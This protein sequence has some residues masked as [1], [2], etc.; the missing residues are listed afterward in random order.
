MLVCLVWQPSYKML[1]LQYTLAAWLGWCC[2]WLMF[3]V[4]LLVKSQGINCG[5][6]P[7]N[8]F[9][10]MKWDINQCSWNVI[11]L[12]FFNDLTLVKALIF[13]F[14]TGKNLLV[15]THILW[16]HILI[17]VNEFLWNSHE[18][19]KHMGKIESITFLEWICFSQANI[20][21][22]PL[23]WENIESSSM[24]GRDTSPP[25]S[26]WYLQWTSLLAPMSRWWRNTHIR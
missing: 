19:R 26:S 6:F 5:M 2:K 16:Q 22:M 24:T 13:I 23:E 12:S 20:D 11:V 8:V 3:H 25:S 9:C 14:W 18:A 4:E 10:F 17:L 21:D 7:K 1:R 15:E